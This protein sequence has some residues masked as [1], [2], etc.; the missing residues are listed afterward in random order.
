MTKTSKIL[1]AGLL[2]IVAFGCS[3][4][5]QPVRQSVRIP[6]RIDLTQHEMIGVVQFK[7]TAKGELGPLITRRFTEV[8]RQD[9]G[10]VR[11]VGFGPQVR[12]GSTSPDAFKSLGHKHG[13]ATLVLGELTVSDVRPDLSLSSGLR[14]GTL[15]AKVDATLEVQLIE[16]SSGASIWSSSARA[17]Q[18]VGHISV[19]GGGDFSFDADDPERAY[20]NLVDALVAHVTRDFR[21]TW[22]QQ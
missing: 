2:V 3:G 8:A 11:M 12:V 13:V 6:P 17:T 10:L 7:T 21:A 18:S 4:Q 19:F 15:S 20:G 16:T 22:Q 9:Q 5:R 1:S 14:S